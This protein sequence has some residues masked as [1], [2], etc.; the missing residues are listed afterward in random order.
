MN[1]KSFAFSAAAGRVLIG[2]LFLISGVGKL[3]APAATKAYIA[4]SGMPLPDLGFLAALIIEVGFGLAL[5]LGYRTRLVA[6]VMALFALVTAVMFHHALG[7]TNQFIHFFKNVS[8][9]GGLLQ[10]VAFGA[11]ALSL[12]ALRERRQPQLR[13]AVL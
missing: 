7:D 2:A 5:V 8:I 1:T 4:A 6:A 3:A 13:A 9:A 11:G 12:D 10:V